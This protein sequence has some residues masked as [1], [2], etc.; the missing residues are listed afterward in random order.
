M[1]ADRNGDVEKLLSDGN[2]LLAEIQRRRDAISALLDGTRSRCPSSCA[3]SSPTTASSCGRPSRQLDRVAALLQRN[4]D[5]LEEALR[6]QAVFVR[7]FANA[8]GNGQW[9]DN[10]ICG[11]FPPPLGPL[12]PEGC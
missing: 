5:Q 3:A 8:I 2:L 11:L 7:L 6:N 10:Y 1:L 9:F 12:N 4:Q